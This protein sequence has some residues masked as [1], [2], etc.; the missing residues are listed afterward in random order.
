MLTYS[1]SS[2][3]DF[4]SINEDAWMNWQL[5]NGLQKLRQ[6]FIFW[7]IWDWKIICYTGCLSYKFKIF[8]DTVFESKI[9]D[10]FKLLLNLGYPKKK[11]EWFQ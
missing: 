6:E 7:G 3:N 2:F 9:E 11:I 8:Q 10:A 5:Q 1:K 4:L